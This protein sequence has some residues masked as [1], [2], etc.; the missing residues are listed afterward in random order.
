MMVDAPATLAA[1]TAERPSAP[2]PLT[3]T[4]VPASTA[5]VLRIAP[6][7]VWIPQ[8]SGPM[9]RIGADEFTFTT[10]VSAAMVWVAND[11]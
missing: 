11:D 8:P 5:N 4:L 1:I 2:A 10:D 6:A 9:V 3:T 7:P